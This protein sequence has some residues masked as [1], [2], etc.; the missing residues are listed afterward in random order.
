MVVLLKQV[1]DF[2]SEENIK[3]KIGC[4]DITDLNIIAKH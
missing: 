3:W 4:Q 1:T 2:K